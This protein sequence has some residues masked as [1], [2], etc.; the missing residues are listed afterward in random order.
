MHRKR[1]LYLNLVINLLI[2]FILTHVGVRKIA[3]LFAI[4]C[5][6]L[7]IGLAL[8]VSMLDSI[9]LMVMEILLEHLC[10]RPISWEALAHHIRMCL[11][12]LLKRSMSARKVRLFDY[13]QA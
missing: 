12:C 11:A 9:A 2:S 6:L 4:G 5:S 3:V 7:L 8:H 13:S 1:L 10:D